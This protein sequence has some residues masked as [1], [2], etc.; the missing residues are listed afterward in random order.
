MAAKTP[1]VTG[2][3]LLALFLSVGAAATCFREWQTTCSPAE[4]SFEYEVLS[5]SEWAGER[6]NLVVTS[7]SNQTFAVSEC[8]S[9][10]YDR[11]AS[12]A[13]CGELNTTRWVFSDNLAAVEIG[14]TS[15]NFNVRVC[16][17]CQ[18]GDFFKLLLTFEVENGACTQNTV[19]PDATCNVPTTR[20][21]GSQA[22]QSSTSPAS[23]VQWL[24]PVHH[25]G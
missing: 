22:S 24:A 16:S 14:E 9:L 23:Q 6:L 1:T 25:G 10:G 3:L 11:C 18:T 21:A 4:S 2:A 15:R 13:E 20:C 7:P 12:T 17:D 19:A 8:V 5:N